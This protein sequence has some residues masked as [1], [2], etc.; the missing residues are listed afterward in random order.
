MSLFLCVA[1]FYH[2]SKALC[3][4]ASYSMPRVCS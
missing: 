4:I 3:V 1:A 2:S